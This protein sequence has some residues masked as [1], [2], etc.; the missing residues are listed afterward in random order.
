MKPTLKQHLAK[1]TIQ[2]AKRPLT[3]GLGKSLHTIGLAVK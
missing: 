1:R 2:H 3:S